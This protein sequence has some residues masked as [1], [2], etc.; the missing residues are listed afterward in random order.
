MSAHA[1]VYQSV[2]DASYADIDLA[3]E[4][5]SVWAGLDGA[6]KHLAD[7]AAPISGRQHCG[8]Y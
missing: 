4:C 8:C 1:H 6:L 2:T 5:R 7:T 3:P